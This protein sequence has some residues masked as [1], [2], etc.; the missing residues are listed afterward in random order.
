M[1]GTC[2]SATFVRLLPLTTGTLK[3]NSDV[4]P[5]GSVAVA[6]MT[7][8]TGTTVEELATKLA[9]PLASVVTETEPR[10]VW[11]WPCPEGSATGLANNSMRNVV[12]G[13]LCNVPATTV[14]MLLASAVV[15]CGIVLQVVRAGVGVERVI[16][17][18]AI[19]AIGAGRQ[20]DAN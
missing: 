19:A 17:R 6:E 20:I 1:D 2:N 9:F 12:L 13:V 18:D 16:R 3:E 4:L 10:Y 11:P 8:P 7:W 14:C 15:I 5:A